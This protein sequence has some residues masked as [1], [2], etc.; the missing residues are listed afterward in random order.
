MALLG[1]GASDSV[2]EGEGNDG[3]EGEAAKPQKH[4][5][6]PL[7]ITQRPKRLNKTLQY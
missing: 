4:Y 2:G 7:N 5:T 1:Q 3:G 6:N